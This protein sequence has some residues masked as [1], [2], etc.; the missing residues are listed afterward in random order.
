MS[1][2]AY[3]GNVSYSDYLTAK[4][5]IGD[6]N[7]ATRESGQRVSMEISN[8][9]RNII[10]SN[11][12]LAR[13]GIQAMEYATERMTYVLQDGFSRL[14]YDLGEISS[15]ISKLHA[16]F[17]WGFGQMIAGIGRMNDSL[18]ALIKIAKTPAQ[19]AAYE[20]FQ[21]ARDA[22]RQ[23][24]YAECLEALDKAISG[25][26]ISSGYKLEWRFHKMKGTIL[27]GF[28]GGDLSLQDLTGAEESF[29][30]AARY[31]KADYPDHAGQAFLSA[32][33]A[34][35]CQG[36][37]KEALTHIEQAMAISPTLGE[38]FFLAA[39][40]RM[41][42]GQVDAA[43]PVL[44][45]AVD[46]DKF[47]ALKAAGDADF[48]KYD[49]KL[50]DFLEAMRQEKYQQSMPLVKKALERIR[51]WLEHSH[52]AE[53]HDA[54]KRLTSFLSEGERLP[55]LDI[56]AVLPK[57][58]PTI[59][60]IEKA[61]KDALILVLSWHSLGTR[62]KDVQCPIEEI[63]DEEVCV[64]PRG[65]FKKAVY[66]KRQAIRTVTKTCR[67]EHTIEEVRYEY[68]NGV[69]EKL[70][71]K[72]TSMEFCF[73]PAGKFL[74][75]E[76][77]D[78][79]RVTI[80][81]HFLLGKCQVTQDQWEAIMGNNPS[82]YKGGNRPVDSV[83]WNDCQAFIK[84]LNKLSD[85]VFRLP[86]EAEWE[87]ACRAGATTAYCF[88]NNEG[89]LEEYAWYCDNSKNE[90]NPVGKKEEN[91]WG[92]HDMHGNVWEW[93]Q[94]YYGDYP[95]GSVTD[96]AGPSTGEYR[97]QRGGSCHSKE[98]DVRASKRAWYIPANKSINVG[99]RLVLSNK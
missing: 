62:E 81:H 4:S 25:D 40:V 92:L 33:W 49:G 47:F 75:G 29:L 65:L 79:H 89:Q 15:G 11:E 96:P 14:S 5:F 9:T 34:A 12:A 63:Y 23:G 53:H 6:I 57:L 46:L 10:A 24:L 7:T 1:Y 48:Q 22:Y 51:F 99:F 58:K 41:A 31:A 66:E 16:T 70:N 84:Q 67:V 83:S 95:K 35:Y 71:D 30:L 13:E 38:A 77:K 28:V 86:T 27:L 36:R 91:A 61:A 20:Q 19:S 8:Q 37:L 64:K 90:T 85:S 56:L 94:D 42:L 18:D 39:K 80:N 78:Q 21:I 44:R 98:N 45:R 88:G 82:Q 72:V 97:V 69:G 50:R 93:C 68:F 60:E 55:F 52:D 87:Y 43:F 74:M 26:H 59:E 76:G 2:Y 54:V 17:H 3:G 32:G 73:I